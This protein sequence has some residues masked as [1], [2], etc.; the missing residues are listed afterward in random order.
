MQMTPEYALATAYMDASALLAV[1]LREPSAPLI[2][3]R[4]ETFDLLASARLL[5]AE[6]PPLSPAMEWI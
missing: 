1:A 4:L 5:E 3:R 2:A 6:V